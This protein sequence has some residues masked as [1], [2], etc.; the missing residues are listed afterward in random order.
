MKWK[1]IILL[2]VAVLISGCSFH[3]EN[4]ENQKNENYYKL[5]TDTTVSYTH[6]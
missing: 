6:L 3:H 4:K 2:M 1:I 5:N